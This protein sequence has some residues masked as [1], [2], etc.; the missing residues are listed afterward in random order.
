MSEHIKSKLY[1]RSKKKIFQ[2]TQL[3][4]VK[5]HFTSVTHQNYF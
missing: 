5:Y 1:H 3:D 2:S 4:L